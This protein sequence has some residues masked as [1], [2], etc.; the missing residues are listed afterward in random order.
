MIDPWLGLIGLAVAMAQKPAGP[1]HDP[2]PSP[3]CPDDMRLV[4][5]LH[6]EKVAHIC[7][8]APPE[9]KPARAG[10]KKSNDEVHCY[11]YADDFTVLEP[12]VTP[13]RVCMDQFEA[14]NRRGANPLVMESFKSA[15][16]WCAQ[17][18]KRTCSEQE[19]ELACEGGEH[20]PLSYG[21]SVNVKLCNSNK[22]WKP[23]DFAKFDGPHDEALVES[24]KLWQG[25]PSGHY[26][27]C[28]SP[29]GIFDMQ[30]NVEEWVSSRASRKWPGALMGGFWAKAWTGC[31][32]TNDAHQPTFAFYETGFRCCKDPAEKSGKSDKKGE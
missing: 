28:M 11:H 4:E 32:G 18:R 15:S 31:R 8:D 13:V 21:W 10:K 7:L 20:R 17:R 22:P 6:Y 9:P 24:N 2:G 27:T 1:N 12:P 29:F 25:V 19:W 5:G 26:Q 30:G 14:P 16:H 3:S 23:V